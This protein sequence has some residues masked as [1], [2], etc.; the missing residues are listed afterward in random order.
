M[1]NSNINNSIFNTSFPSY[2]D[3]GSLF[4]DSNY[5]DFNKVGLSNSLATGDSK[6]MISTD[7]IVMAE[8]TDI[9]IG[10]ISLKDSIKRIEERLNI[11]TVNHELEKD[12]EE[13]RALGQKYRE[14]EK[15]IMDK[16]SVWEL[17]KKD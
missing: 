17:L 4:T 3:S 15:D 12:W 16:M 8:Q 11:L 6:I 10:N 14:L 13:L 9:K 7:G 2:T 5:I 1:S